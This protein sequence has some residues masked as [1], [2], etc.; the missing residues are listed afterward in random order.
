MK[1]NIY[2]YLVD[3]PIATYQLL[4]TIIMVTSVMEG[5]TVENTAS[6]LRFTLDRS[7]NNLLIIL[8]TR[9]I[10]KWSS[11]WHPLLK[12]RPWGRAWRTDCAVCGGELCLHLAETLYPPRGAGFPSAASNPADTKT[13]SGE[14]SWA[15]GITTDL[16]RHNHTGCFKRQDIG[17][18]AVP[19]G[20]L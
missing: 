15:M 19:T 4:K 2:F 10:I 9:R 6:A 5:C 16:W 12:T 7:C 11:F 20:C 17:A 8:N 13:T 14:N 3:P 18:V 1:T